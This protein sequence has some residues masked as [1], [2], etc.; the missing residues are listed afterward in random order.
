MALESGRD[1]EEAEVRKYGALVKSL[2]RLSESHQDHFKR[3]EA[4]TVSLTDRV[5]KAG[6]VREAL[7]GLVEEAFPPQMRGQT[8]DAQPKSALKGGRAA[9]NSQQ[10][11]EMI[12]S[13]LE[14]PQNADADGSGSLSAEHRHELMV[15][16]RE[17]CARM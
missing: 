17:E 10:A 16:L 15:D 12:K 5:T 4:A 2:Q 9:G 7:R 11:L 3:L 1:A 8:D 14:A 6:D 13:L